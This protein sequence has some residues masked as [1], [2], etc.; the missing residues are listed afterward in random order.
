MVCSCG[1]IAEENNGEGEICFPAADQPG[2][3]GDDSDRNGRS[4]SGMLLDP[5]EPGEQ[6]YKIKHLFSPFFSGCS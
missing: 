1:F 6:G 2:N 4:E 5:Y 3:E